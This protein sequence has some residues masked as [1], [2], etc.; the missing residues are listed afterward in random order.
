MNDYCTVR[1]VSITYKKSLKFWSSILCLIMRG[2][3]T[4]EFCTK[5]KY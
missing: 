4:P 2:D 3:P 5:R 1:C